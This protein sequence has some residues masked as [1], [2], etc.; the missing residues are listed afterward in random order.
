MPGLVSDHIEVE[1]VGLHAPTLALPDTGLHEARAALG[2]RPVDDRNEFGARMHVAVPPFDPVAEIVLPYVE[3]EPHR[4]ELV[5]GQKLRGAGGNVVEMSLLV[6]PRRGQQRA[7]IGRSIARRIVGLRLAGGVRHIK[8]VVGGSRTDT[9]GDRRNLHRLGRHTLRI[10]GKQ[11]EACSAGTRAHPASLCVK[12]YS[13][14]TA[15]WNA[16]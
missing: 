9:A 13:R 16:A 8:R 7:P 10:D 14:H 15:R 11:P 6:R 1:G 3:R 2:I 4:A 12:R 5:R